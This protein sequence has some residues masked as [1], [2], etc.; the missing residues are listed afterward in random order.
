MGTAQ[1]GARDRAVLEAVVANY[2]Y[3]AEPV[4]SRTISKRY[5]FGLSAA[6]IR[7]IMADLEE[8][9]F[10]EQVHT[11]SGRVPTDQGYRFYVDHLE[12]FPVLAPEDQQTIEMG[13]CAEPDEPGDILANTSKI[14]S[15]VARLCGL[16]VLPRPIDTV[17]RSFQVT[18]LRSRQYLVVLVG[19]SGLVYSKVVELG[20]D[21]VQESLDAMCRFLS[22]EFRGMTL[23]DIRACLGERLLVER[24][25]YNMLLRKAMELAEKALPT[26][27]ESGEVILGGAANILS[28]P[29][30][31][32]DVEK[33]RRIFEAFEEKAKLL[34][35]LDQCMSGEGMSILIGSE[36]QVEEMDALSFIFHPYRVGGG[37]AGWIGIFGPKRMHYSR[38]IAIVDYTAKT[39]NRVLSQ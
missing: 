11:S 4:G 28:Y 1:L 21:I 31:T 8:M 33:M 2:I 39:L 27:E 37:L 38:N 22:S 32:G 5:G 10:L 34:L 9:G 15:T 18:R 13:Y 16:V 17:V 20:E 6:T 3:T 36:S 24:E 30:F 25:Q 26:A 23:G 12:S 14:L 35:I 29:E 7:N 19:E